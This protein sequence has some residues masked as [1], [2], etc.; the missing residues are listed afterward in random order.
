MMGTERLR[1][2][3]TSTRRAKVRC[4]EK[5]RWGGGPDTLACGSCH[6]IPPATKAHDPGL[7][8]ADCVRCHAGSVGAG[9]A[10]LVGG[11]HLNGVVDVQN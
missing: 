11:A 8:L 2:I 5:P 1:R 7:G 10:I 9:G 3:P 4:G 6:G